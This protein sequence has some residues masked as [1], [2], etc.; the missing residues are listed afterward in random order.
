M[1]DCDRFLESLVSDRLDEASRAHA[2]SCPVC[3]PL[4]PGEPPHDPG[5]AASLTAV[6]GQIGRASCRERV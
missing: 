6:H 4:L 5:S 2:A 3:G 1:S